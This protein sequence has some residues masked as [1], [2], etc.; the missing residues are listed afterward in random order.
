VQ[1]CGEEKL[2]RISDFKVLAKK[3]LA[4]TNIKMFGL[5]DLVNFASVSASEDGKI[6]IFTPQVS[7]HA[8]AK[9][10]SGIQEFYEKWR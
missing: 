4:I 5:K 9:F 6:V 2:W 8:C 7:T 10:L 3:T 1:N